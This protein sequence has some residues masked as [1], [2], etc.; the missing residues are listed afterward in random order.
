MKKV[1]P[2]CGQWQYSPSYGGTFYDCFH[3]CAKLGFAP[4]VEPDADESK[5]LA[6]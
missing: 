5:A 1:C 6:I 4:K 3:E 2:N